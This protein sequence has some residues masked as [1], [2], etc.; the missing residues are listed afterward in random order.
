MYEAVDR[1]VINLRGGKLER[2]TL[3]ACD[4]VQSFPTFLLAL[5]VLSAVD[6]PSRFHIG[7][8]F[9]IG[10]WAPFARLALAQAR[11]LGEAQ[12]VEAARALGANRAGSPVTRSS[13]LA[14]M[15]TI[16]SASRIAQFA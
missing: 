16:Q 7:A 10:V 9:C 4:L 3:R 15:A 6:V 13:N 8:V 12:F 5:A 11:T 1:L 2:W 14:P